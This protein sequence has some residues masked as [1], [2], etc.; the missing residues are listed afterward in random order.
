M[1]VTVYDHLNPVGI[2]NRQYYTRQEYNRSSGLRRHNCRVLEEEQGV[3]KKE[4]PDCIEVPKQ[5]SKEGNGCGQGSGEHYGC[6]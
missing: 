3:G 6:W 2:H 5:D 4:G 1:D